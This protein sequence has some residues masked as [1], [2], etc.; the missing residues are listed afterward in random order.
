[1]FDEMKESNEGETIRSQRA[2]AEQEDPSAQFK[3]ALMYSK[4][5]EV[6][7]NADEAFFWYEKAAKNGDINAQFALATIYADELS[8]KTIYSSLY[9]GI[10]YLP[11]MGIF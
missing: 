2:L 1:M 4:G 7:Q 11:K 9:I 3:L 5:H 6:E 8:E 10:K